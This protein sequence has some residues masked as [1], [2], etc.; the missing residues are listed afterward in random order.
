[1][2][3]CV[4]ALALAPAAH[5]SDFSLELTAPSSATYGDAIVL[6]G[7][8]V[9]ALADAPS[10][11]SATAWRSE[12]RRPARRDVRAAHEGRRPGRLLRLGR[13]LVSASAMLAA[14][15]R[16]TTRVVGSGSSA[17]RFGCW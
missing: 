16:L 3:V 12:P 11:C 5:A 1:V 15:P 7:R 17:R 13:R 6:R 8:V 9:P 10:R 14:K 2:A 4:I